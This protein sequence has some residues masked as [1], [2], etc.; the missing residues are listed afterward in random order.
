MSKNVEIEIIL[1][2]TFSDKLLE[3]IFKNLKKDLSKNSD[4]M[5]T[6]SYNDTINH[7]YSYKIVNN[8]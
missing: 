4:S 3:D 2:E 6:I 5:I 7:K 1:K 8:D